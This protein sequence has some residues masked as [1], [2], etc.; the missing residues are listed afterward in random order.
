MTCKTRC[1]ILTCSLFL[2]RS[3]DAR[4]A[5]HEQGLH[6]FTARH[7]RVRW[8]KAL[9]Q[10]SPRH[11]LTRHKEGVFQI[12]GPAESGI[13]KGITE[14]G[15]LGFVLTSKRRVVSVRR[16]DY[17]RISIS[18]ARYEDARIASRND[19]DLVSHSRAAEHFGEM[20]WLEDTFTVS[21]DVTLTDLVQGGRL[22]RNGVAS[23]AG[24][25]SLHVKVRATRR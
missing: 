23:V 5:C 17:Q 7:L 8:L 6:F 10:F 16:G 11:Q 4:G 22:T 12:V 13:E 21:D 3:R 9:A 18:Q 20:G 15:P 19:H 2:N 14:M 25:L 24:T 1:R